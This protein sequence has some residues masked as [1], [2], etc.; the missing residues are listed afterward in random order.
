MSRGGFE[1]NRDELRKARQTMAGLVNT[2]QV[3]ALDRFGVPIRVGDFVVV[4]LPQDPAMQVVDIKPVLRPDAQPGTLEVT[5]AVH[6]PI[7]VRAG[8]PVTNMLLVGSMTQEDGDA[9]PQPAAAAAAGGARAD[10]ASGGPD[11]DAGGHQA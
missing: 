5:V 3:T 1:R 9:A 11:G 2:G 8:L 10:G 7:T 6:F 4:R